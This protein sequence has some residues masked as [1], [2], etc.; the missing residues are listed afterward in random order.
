MRP[1]VGGLDATPS[2]LRGKARVVS[3]QTGVDKCSSS[4]S[5]RITTLFLGSC[6]EKTCQESQHRAY[7][8]GRVWHPSWPSSIVSCCSSPP[9]LLLTRKKCTV[10]WIS[11]L[12]TRRFSPFSTRM[13]MVL[14]LFLLVLF[15]LL[16]CVM[17]FQDADQDL[18]LILRCN[19]L[20]NMRTCQVTSRSKNCAP[21]SDH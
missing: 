4:P 1:L 9:C 15:L 8:K 19:L 13:E 11:Q 2:T 10:S 16:F 7:K 5:R 21:S 17:W 6:T 18:M 14:S 12:S 3:A 20:A